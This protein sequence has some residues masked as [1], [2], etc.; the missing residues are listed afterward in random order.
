MPKHTHIMPQQKHFTER[1]GTTILGWYGVSALGQNPNID[2][3]ILGM[4]PENEREP[5]KRTVNKNT[6]LNLL[7]P[8]V[9]EI[10]HK[11]IGSLIHLKKTLQL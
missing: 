8:Y 4:I 9:I 5:K 7:P 1:N 11:M 6:L 3:E 10:I 2:K